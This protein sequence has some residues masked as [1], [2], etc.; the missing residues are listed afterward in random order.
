MSISCPLPLPLALSK[1]V[2]S[3]CIT[4]PASTTSPAIQ[5]FFPPSLLSCLPEPKRR[6]KSNRD[7]KDCNINI[8]MPFKKKKKSHISL[9]TRAAV[10]RYACSPCGL[11]SKGNRIVC[12]HQSSSS[13]LPSPRTQL[14]AR[15]YTINA[16]H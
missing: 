14:D 3:C 10:T 2:K 9:Y 5:L 6:N 1:P 16:R 8:L 11:C 7:S 4:A 15:I 12:Q 13:P